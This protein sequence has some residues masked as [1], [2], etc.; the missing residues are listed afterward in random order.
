MNKEQALAKL[1]SYYEEEMK[2]NQFYQQTKEGQDLILKLMQTTDLFVRSFD[3]DLPVGHTV[4]NKIKFFICRVIRRMTRFITKPYAEGMQKYNESVCELFGQMISRYNEKIYNLEMHNIK[5]KEKKE[6]EKQQEREQREKERIQGDELRK[7][8]NEEERNR[9]QEREKAYLEEIRAL[10]N[11]ID[12]LN[13]IVEGVKQVLNDTVNKTLKM[14]G[15]IT[16]L[17]DAKGKKIEDEL[18][19]NSYS[20]AG[21]DKI[22]QFIFDYINKKQALV[23]YLDIGCNHY[24]KLNNT[25]SLYQKGHRGVL[26]EANP[27]FIEELREKR[28]GDVVLNMGVAG[29]SADSM[30]FYITNADGLNS[31]DLNS[32]QEAKK[33]LEWLQVEKEVNVPVLT[34]EDII[35]QYCGKTPDIVSIDVEGLE[36]D[37]LTGLDFDEHRPKAFIIETINYSTKLQI[38]AKREDIMEFMHTKGYEEYAFTGVNS[39]FIDMSIIEK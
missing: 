30:K 19:E 34:M 27:G 33:K 7:K 5:E 9:I 35:N 28:P 17:A 25:Y 20:Q 29:H 12:E 3:Y 36:I 1:S 21:E 15:E 14:D 6:R 32:I 16:I 13:E 11:K 31:F 26:V 4:K 23:S 2:E 37:I 39:I 10:K 38:N 8:E 22:V 18:K 24:R